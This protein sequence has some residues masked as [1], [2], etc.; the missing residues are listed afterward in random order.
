MPQFSPRIFSQF[1]PSFS[2][3]SYERRLRVN[4]CLFLWYPVFSFINSKLYILNWTF[5]VN[6]VHT[7]LYS[8]FI[9]KI[10]TQINILWNQAMHFYFFFLFSR[11]VLKH[12]LILYFS[13]IFMDKLFH[14]CYSSNKKIR[15]K[16][17]I[18]SL[19][20]KTW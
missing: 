17:S 20:V 3:G 5:E 10:I 16:M 13:S 1:E 9:N 19:F 18:W 6:L 4:F 12:V 8:I 2:C 7:S 15:H 14:F 11:F